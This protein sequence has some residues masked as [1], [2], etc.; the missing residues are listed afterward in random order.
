MGRHFLR[1]YAHIWARPLALLRGFARARQGATAV[2]FG[3]IAGPFIATLLVIF[4]VS[5]LFLIGEAF[6]TGMTAASRQIL[7]GQAQNSSGSTKIT[8]QSTFRQ[9]AVCPNLPS[10]VDCSKVVTNVAQFNNFSSVSQQGAPISSG[11]LNTSS[12]GYTPCQ[13]TKGIQK[14]MKV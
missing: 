14:I 5:Y 6:D 3:L 13:T 2:E 8:D 11:T 1:Q 7:T 4:E 10:F 12:W 9:Y